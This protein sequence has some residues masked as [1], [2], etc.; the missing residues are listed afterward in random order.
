MKR[1]DKYE[2]AVDDKYVPINNFNNKEKKVIETALEIIQARK[3]NKD[4]LA[5]S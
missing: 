4:L 3:K 1:F 2:A 5:K